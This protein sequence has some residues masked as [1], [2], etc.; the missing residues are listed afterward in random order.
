[1][2]DRFLDAEKNAEQL[3]RTLSEL[4]GEAVSYKNSTKELN[5]VR[6]KLVTLIESN[7]I[8]A[9]DT[10]EIVKSINSI[11]G[12]EIFSELKKISHL[13]NE[14]SNKI[15]KK[16]SNNKVLIYIGMLLSILSLIGIIMI[17][18]RF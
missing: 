8:I 13:V 11:G 16:L 4:R 6:E 14:Q 1:M 15:T 18:F 3:V 7:Q 10:Y 17:F 12:P 9:K 5:V 2:N